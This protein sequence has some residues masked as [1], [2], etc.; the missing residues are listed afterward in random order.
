MVKTSTTALGSR[1]RMGMRATILA[2]SGA[3]LPHW[4]VSVLMSRVQASGAGIVCKVYVPAGSKNPSN[5]SGRVVTK[6]VARFAPV[7]QMRFHGTTLPKT[8][9]PRFVGRP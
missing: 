5:S 8:M 9:R 2:G 6:C 4:P 7:R 3:T 1:T